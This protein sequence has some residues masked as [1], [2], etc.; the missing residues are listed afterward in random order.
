M[1]LLN[2]SVEKIDWLSLSVQQSWFD[3]F[4]STN[5]NGI[6]FNKF[7]EFLN[8][9]IYNYFE[10]ISKSKKSCIDQVDEKNEDIKF[11]YQQEMQLF[12]LFDNKNDHVIDRD[13]FTILCQSWLHKI[14]HRSCA[15]VI[16]DVQNDFIDGSLALI[17]GPA[18]QDG[19]DVVPVIN[20][21][22]ENCS[23]Q[24]V[25]YTQ[26]WHPIDH[27]GFHENLHLRKYLIKNSESSAT[28]D[29]KNSI[30]DDN[31]DTNEATGHNENLERANENKK[32]LTKAK[33]FDTVLFDG[34]RMEQKL[35]PIHCVQNSWGAELH[36]KLKIVPDSI[37][38][39]KGTLSNVDAYSAFWDNMHLNETGLTQE[40]LSRKI[41]DV[42]F[43]GLAL[44]YC[45]SASALDSVKAGFTTFVIEDACK[46]ISNE[47]IEKRKI[48]MLDNGI[49]IINSKSVNSY[50]SQVGKHKFLDNN[51]NFNEGQSFDQKLFLNIC[52][53]RALGL[54][55]ES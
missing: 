54:R 46:G 26:D 20:D 41:D 30:N 36:S 29:N 55:G 38:I 5:E 9:T 21:L 22:L 27:I 49:F 13:E 16:V 14:F 48:E 8:E 45:V 32:L 35:W 52:F 10:T 44:D 25:V 39:Y 28:N 11:T 53:K 23:F 3:K 37:R 18:E 15:L 7:Q 47:E 17:N 6:K 1:E 50:I 40:L 34:G 19:A 4:K 31:Y 43:C 51:N 12:R 42:F 24:T 2:N 33:L